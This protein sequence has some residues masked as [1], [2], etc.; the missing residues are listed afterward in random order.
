[1][2]DLASWEN[3][4]DYVI[5]NVT[6]VDP[7]NNRIHDGYHVGIKEGRIAFVEPGKPQ[8]ASMS[9]FD[10]GGLH[11]AP[12]FVD[13][14]VH[15]RE[16]GQEYKETILTGTRAAVA[17]GF[18]SVACMPNTDPVADEN[19]IVEFIIKKAKI[20]GFAKVY[21]I[22]AATVGSK[23]EKLTEFASLVEAGAVAVSD[24][25]HPVASAQ[26][27]R[28][29]LEYASNYNIPFIEHCEDMSASANG[30]MNE[31]FT[32]TRLGLT[33]I[34][35][36]SEQICLARDLLVLQ[37]VEVP[38]HAAHMSTKGSVELIREAKRRGLP[39]TAETA[40]HY[41]AFDDT[42]LGTY[43]TNLKINPPIR[44]VEDREALIEGLIDGTIDCIVSD[45]APHAA[46][47]K[48]VEFENA[49]NGAIGLETTFSVVMTHLV[50]PG[51]MAIADAL[52]LITNKPAKVLNLPA[53]GIQPGDAADL[54]LF[55][56][57]EEWVVGKDDFHSKSHNSP[58]IGQTLNGRVKH[59]IVDG[60]VVTA[61]LMH[62]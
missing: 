57:K 50:K 44:G 41:L 25:G 47:E 43:D 6:V 32:S 37:S 24:D 45:H 2:K 19:S 34:P 54:T 14:H 38:F 8:V 35:G 52:S 21:P 18:T 39:V 58:F 4:K 15:L 36:Y 30:V 9:V 48:Q 26:M 23:G 28:R 20:A 42:D 1:M 17:G 59:T 31:G 12:G 56:P 61:T 49:P 27:V 22:A 33:G 53:G 60:S 13:I 7:S 62:V 40:P 11:I 16:P 29:V 3:E 51:H 10:G 5:A 55:D 46:H